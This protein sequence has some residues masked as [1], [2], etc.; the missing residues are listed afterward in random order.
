MNKKRR[1]LPDGT[2]RIIAIAATIRNENK[3]AI[4][5]DVNGNYTGMTRENEPPVQDADDL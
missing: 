5:S 4:P 1:N 3:G 2:K